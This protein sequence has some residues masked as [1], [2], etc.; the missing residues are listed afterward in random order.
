MGKT[1]WESIPFHINLRTMLRLSVLATLF[2]TTIL[3]LKPLWGQD[4]G[5]VVEFIKK[6]SGL[7]ISEMTRTGVPASIKLAQG[8]LESSAGHSMLAISSNN[9]FGI[10]CGADLKGECFYKIDDGK[11]SSCFRVYKSVSESFIDHSNHLTKH[12]RYRFLFD[13]EKYDFLSWAY[14]LSIAGYATDSTY[15]QKIIRIVLAF[16]LYNY[17]FLEECMADDMNITSSSNF[18]IDSINTIESIY[19]NY[20][21]IPNS[22]HLYVPDIMPTRINIPPI[23]SPPK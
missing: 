2:I 5:Q 16:E 3:S 19:C 18:S 12:P 23:F 22:S 14:G 7:A 13:Y 9:H 11:D 15:P 4:K 20:P 6:H 21:T 10:K 1:N 8:I 17:D